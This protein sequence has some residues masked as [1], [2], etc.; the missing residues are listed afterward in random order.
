[1]D[2]DSPL[3]KAFQKPFA[4]H[5]LHHRED[6]GVRVYD[7]FFPYG[8]GSKMERT[9]LDPQVQSTVSTGSSKSE[10]FGTAAPQTPMIQS[11]QI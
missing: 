3:G 9:G 1:M 5:Q 4:L 2:V 8:I 7:R 10:D 6:R 11:L